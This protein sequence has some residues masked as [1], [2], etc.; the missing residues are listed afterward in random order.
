MTAPAIGL[1]AGPGRRFDPVGGLARPA[2]SD[3]SVVDVHN[4]GM[5][6]FGGIARWYWVGT[7]VVLLALYLLVLG[8]VADT[9]NPNLVPTLLLL[10][11]LVVPLTF[12]TF[13][14]GWSGPQPVPASTLGAALLF[15]GVIGVVVA[16]VLEY[17]T[18]RALGALPMAAVGLIEESAKLA[19]AAV[20]LFVLRRRARHSETGSLGVGAGIVLG[21]AVGTGFA[22]L[23]TM[24]YGFVALIQSG[25]NVGAVEQ[26]LFL[27]G[28]MSPAG[29]AAWT[30]L[31]CW[32]LWLLATRPNA[33]SGAAFAGLLVLAIVLHTCWDSIGTTISYLVV[34]VLSIGLLLIGL[35][36]ARRADLAT[37]PPLGLAT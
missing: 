14:R 22:V 8:A 23:E 37:A 24:G 29:H 5:N 36:Q 26:T 13:A 1:V 2:R 16:G 9:G 33:R 10:G 11:A 3:L 20:L 27:R 25:G 34:A 6:R 12:V 35:R 19:V 32:G 30:G 21:V 7:L 4:V 15:G 31:T 28:V 18:M 17:D